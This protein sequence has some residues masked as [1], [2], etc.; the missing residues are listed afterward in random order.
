MERGIGVDPVLGRFAVNEGLKCSP[1][2]Q[3][4]PLPQKGAKIE[5]LLGEKTPFGHAGGGHPDAV[6]LPAEVA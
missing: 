1:Q 6:A 5:R 3:L 4:I 2:R